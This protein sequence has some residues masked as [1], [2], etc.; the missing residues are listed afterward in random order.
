VYAGNSGR[1]SG[2]PDDRPRNSRTVTPLTSEYAA[3][4]P[5]PSARKRAAKSHEAMI[6]PPKNRNAPMTWTYALGDGVAP[7]PGGAPGG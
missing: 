7:T 1:P 2:P 4:P 5:R 6:N 3:Q